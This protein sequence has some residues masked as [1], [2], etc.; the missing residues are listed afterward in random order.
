MR[1]S[2]AL[3]WLL[4]IAAGLTVAN[5]WYCQPLLAMM[6]ATFGASPHQ[7]GFVAVVT[8]AGY[9]A[10]M[11][12]VIPLG[13][14][15]ER[16]RLMVISA[17]VSAAALLAVGLAPSLPALLVA[18]FAL[19]LSTA[20]PQ[21]SVPYAADL[22]DPRERGRSVGKVMSGLL[23]GILLSRTA[24]GIIGHR[25]GWRAVY[26]IASAVMLASAVLLRLLLPEQMPE[27]RIPY[28]EL[29]RSLPALLRNEPLL[30]RHGILGALALTAFSAFWTTLVFLLA[31]P[32]YHYGADVAGLF[33]LVGVAGALIAPVAGGLADRY[34]TRLVN[35][36][37]LACVLVSWIVFALLW[38][39]L[40]G[41][42]AGVIL[43]DLGVQ[44]NHISNQTRVL[45]L[46]TE[47]R[48]RLNAVYMVMYF[49]GAAIG[50]FLGASA[51]SAFG[52]TAVS[53]LGIFLSAA[54]L[55]AYFFV[56]TDAAAAADHVARHAVAAPQ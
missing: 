17:A 32:P 50:S 7:I 28:G 21:L 41:L 16:R 42:A 51:F 4:A 54:A 37:A 47:L 40:L 2:R 43:L 18:S 1:D 26:L 49:T 55:A 38:R 48:S 22:V 46:S 12:L 53:A 25:L 9:A 27:R 44:A 19:G 24:S 45:G 30:R 35:G 23:I 6:G 15:E 11:I 13:D 36:L 39:S 8:Q 10:A 34:G 20:V 5:L 29:L 33:G 56:E 3:L 31:T 14:S 52:W